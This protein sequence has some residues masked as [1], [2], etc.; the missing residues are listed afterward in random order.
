MYHFRAER[1]RLAG[2]VLK[3]GQAGESFC[4]FWWLRKPE[5]LNIVGLFLFWEREVSYGAVTLATTDHYM[6]AQGSVDI[7]WT[8]HSLTCWSENEK[9]AFLLESDEKNK[10]DH[11]HTAAMFPWS[12]SQGWKR[13]CCDAVFKAEHVGNVTNCSPLPDWSATK[14][15][16][17]KMDIVSFFRVNISLCWATDNVS[18][19]PTSKLKLLFDNVTQYNKKD[20][21]FIFSQILYT[22]TWAQKN[23]TG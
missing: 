4:W 21:T 1:Q 22:I 11:V 13:K 9:L 15:S 18:I 3:Y 8:K 10:T 14:K 12:H 7:Y 5:I 16:W 17:C 20:I 23:A 6:S 2:V 19:Q